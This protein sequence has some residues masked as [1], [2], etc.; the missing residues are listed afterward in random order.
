M[1]EQ[2]YS[3]GYGIITGKGYMVM[4]SISGS[5]SGSRM[6]TTG[7]IDPKLRRVRVENCGPSTPDEDWPHSEPKLPSVQAGVMS[8]ILRL[9]EAVNH[10]A[11][12]KGRIETIDASGDLISKINEAMI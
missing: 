5:R 6:N 10:A 3:E 9:A 1:K 12:N 7:V 8:E 11:V 4:T 2:R